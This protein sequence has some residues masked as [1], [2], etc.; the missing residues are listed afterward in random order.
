[1]LDANV[2]VSAALKPN[3]KPGQIVD[4]VRQG[5]IVLLLSQDILAE[6]RKV[7]RYPKIR[8]ELLISTKEIDEALAEIAQAAILTPG[9]I[10]I[11]A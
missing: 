5:R 9:K 2:F 10:R 7:F 4:L 6:L 8:K 1:M 3:S 11:N